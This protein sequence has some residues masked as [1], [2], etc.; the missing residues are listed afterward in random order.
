MTKVTLENEFG[1]YSVEVSAEVEPID[2]LIS[3][4][5]RPLLL[6][7]GYSERVVDKKIMEDV[8]DFECYG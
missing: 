6:A 3:M 5:I 1:K 2:C 8:D 4:V 7:V